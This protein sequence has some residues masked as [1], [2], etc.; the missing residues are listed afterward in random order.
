M[1]LVILDLH[2]CITSIQPCTVTS[3]CSIDALPL[4]GAMSILAHL[5]KSYRCFFHALPFAIRVLSFPSLTILFLLSFF[6]FC[7]QIT[8]NIVTGLLL[9]HVQVS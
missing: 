8:G 2:L 7:G 3:A 5:E 9:D 1:S 4:K 6:L